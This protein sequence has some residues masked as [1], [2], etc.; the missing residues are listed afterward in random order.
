MEEVVGAGGGEAEGGGGVFFGEQAEKFGADLGL[1]SGGKLSFAGAT[2]GR[3]ALH[4]PG[5]PGPYKG[6]DVDDGGGFGRFR[7]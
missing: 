5:K 2:A 4:G 1:L 7:S 3:L 6:G